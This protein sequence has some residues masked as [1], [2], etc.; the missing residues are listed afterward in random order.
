MSITKKIFCADHNLKLIFITLLALLLLSFRNFLLFHTLIELFSIIVAYL[1]FTINYYS[2][3]K[4]EEY[5]LIFLG[6][7]YGFIGGF[8]FLHTISY[9]GMGIFPGN[10]AN[11][12]T[13]LWIIARYFESISLFI[14]FL[15]LRYKIKFKYKKAMYFFSLISIIL[16]LLLYF[17]LFP[18][19][20]FEESG[21]SLFKIISEYIISLILICS[22]ILL[23]YKRDYFDDYIYKLIKNAI[24]LTIFSEIFFTFYISVYG[25]SNIVGHLF[26]LISYY[27]IF[28]AI[29]ET[30]L[31]EPYKLLFN[32]INRQ[33]AEYEL[34]FNNVQDAIFLVEVE[35]NKE[36]RYMR[37]NP[38]HESLTKLKSE[39]VRGKSPLE[40][41]GKELG[42]KIEKKYRKCLEKKESII[43][44]EKLNLPGGKKTWLTRLTP[45]IINGEVE[46]IVGSSLDI[47]RRKEQEEEIKFL[48]VHDQ[49]TGLY[50][51]RYFQNEISRLNKSRITPICIVIADIDKL[52]F[53]NDNYGHKYGDRYIVKTAE[54]LSM[55]LRDEDI[56]ARVGGDEFAVIF[57]GMNAVFAS[58]I[59]KRI[60]QEISE[61]N[62]NSPYPEALEIS[63]GYS[64]LK[65]SK[66]DLN[67]VYHLAD[68]NMYK[69]KEKKRKL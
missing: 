31:K 67:Q 5:F 68:L 49:L 7:A 8:D 42:Q 46:K 43:Y 30:G 41:L 4:S 40:V 19:C 6:I 26:K 34:I 22:L 52:K 65:N 2:R 56:L 48:S 55:V 15:L 39:E 28:K 24:I 25:I 69:N 13:Q 17:E 16:L 9:K 50:N 37:L 20:Y 14:S 29:V 44:E 66:E 11:L 45:V 61:F 51:R 33:K 35:K 54:I 53:I 62:K 63:L 32:K 38:L 10:G 21:L 1:I 23:R 12:P 59:Y 3:D 57:P 60:H 47:S 64:I 58:K 18:V 27:L 36:M